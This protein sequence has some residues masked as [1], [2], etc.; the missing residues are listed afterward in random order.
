MYLEK[1]DSIGTKKILDNEDSYSFPVLRR[2]LIIQE[3]MLKNY[4]KELDDIFHGLEAYHL[5]KQLN[6]VI[7]DTHHN[8]SQMLGTIENLKVTIDLE[9]IDMFTLHFLL[10]AYNKES[11][12]FQEIYS[13]LYKLQ[14]EDI[15]YKM[16]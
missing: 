13:K 8:I 12:K 15:T 4:E 11:L 9:N 10:K 3:K 6:E 7:T 16:D 1:L 14:E 2:G 5:R